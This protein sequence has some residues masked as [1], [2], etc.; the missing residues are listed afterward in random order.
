MAPESTT[1]TRVWTSRMDGAELAALASVGFRPVGVVMAAVAFPVTLTSSVS[2][3]RTVVKQ[4]P[5]AHQLPGRLKPAGHSGGFI[6]SLSSAQDAARAAFGA[7]CDALTDEARALGAHG[8]MG[9][10]AS[11]APIGK[12]RITP[13]RLIMTGTAIVSGA[14]TQPAKPF[15]TTLSAAPLVEALL[16]G[17]APVRI[18]GAF[19]CT[20]AALGCA[21][22]FSSSRA[23]GNSWHIEALSD[24]IDMSRSAA[25]TEMSDQGAL[26]GADEILGI[27][28]ERDDSLDHRRRGVVLGRLHP[29]R[30]IGNAVTTFDTGL[31]RVGARQLFRL[32][33]SATSPVVPR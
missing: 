8:V 29:V 4:Y 28:L 12:S 20:S 3:S 11:W 1:S 9:V 14:L 2:A 23:V 7:A 22:A 25:V 27:R 18:V 33:T 32:R 5:C 21:T 16:T 26:A 17:R 15:T 24:A 30:A 6:Y 31:S 10:T 19:A 13:H